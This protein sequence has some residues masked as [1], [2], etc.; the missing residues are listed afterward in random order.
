MRTVDRTPRRGEMLKPG[1][2]IDI[3][4]TSQLSLQDRK[5]YNLLV[6]NAF[7]PKMAEEGHEWQ[8]S[9]SKLRRSHKSN[10]RVSD[11]IER[12]MKTVVTARLLNGKTRRFAL[13][14]G[15]DIDDEDRPDGVLNYSFDP[16]LTEVLKQSMS[17]GRLHMAVMMAF[18]S[19]YAL[20][21]YEHVAK[22][23]RLDFKQSETYPVDQFRRILGV[24]EGTLERFS[25]LNQKAIKPALEEVN[26][27]AD[28]T[29]WAKPIKA[30]RRT[31]EIELGWELKSAE[32]CEAAYQEVQRP[33]VGRRARIRGQV[34]SVAA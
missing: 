16:R 29:C 19:R 33:R 12:L 6:H 13:L 11:T 10:D 21:L 25:S 2:M 22:R 32:A 31:E 23:V 20:A 5:V 28:F 30:C 34:D 7:G 18:T 27:L 15:N 17:F 14:G 4:G 26:A 8:I 3:L 9:L 24:P 1:E